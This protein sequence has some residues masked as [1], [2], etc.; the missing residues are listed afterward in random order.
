[1][2][3]TRSPSPA[4]ARWGRRGSTLSGRSACSSSPSG[5]RR[6][7]PGCWRRS[8]SGC[9][10]PESASRG[11]SVL[12]PT[13]SRRSWRSA[14]STR[15]RRCSAGSRSGG[16]RSIELRRSRPRRVAADCLRRR[17]ATP[18]Q[19]SPRSRAP[20]TSTTACTMPFER[21]RTLLALGATQRRTKRKRAARAS[22]EE[23]LT[24]LR[25]ARRRSLGREGTRRARPDQRASALATESSRRPRSASPRSSPKAGR[26]RRW[27]RRSSSATARSSATSRTS[28]RSSACARAPSWRVCLPG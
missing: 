4:S 20:S 1:M 15:P 3:R 16:A 25:R 21:A 2:R 19:R 28:T 24:D 6:R 5:G 13:R 22:L 26:T 14:G 23:A 10:R 11:R 17:E 18:T 9:W 12:S 8:G 27:P 7:L